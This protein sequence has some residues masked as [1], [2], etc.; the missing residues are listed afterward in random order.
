L[1]TTNIP[2]IFWISFSILKLLFAIHNKNS[3]IWIELKYVSY[4]LIHLLARNLQI[5]KINHFKFM[6]HWTY[7]SSSSNCQE[8]VF[9]KIIYINLT[10]MDSRL[11]YVLYTLLSSEQNPFVQ[12]HVY[13]N[14]RL[15]VLHAMILRSCNKLLD[16]DCLW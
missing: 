10:S 13:S 16:T 7:F 1:T 5:L 3:C 4:R 9:I 15:H 6:S 8:C 12:Y 2:K 11:L 14:I